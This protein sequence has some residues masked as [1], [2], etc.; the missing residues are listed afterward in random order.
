MEQR[1]I[2]LTYLLVKTRSFSESE[3]QKRFHFLKTPLCHSHSQ[4]KASAVGPKSLNRALCIARP[5]CAGSPSSTS[6]SFQSPFQV[7]HAHT[8]VLTHLHRPFVCCQSP[9]VKALPSASYRIIRE[10]M[11]THA[12]VCCC[13]STIVK[14]LP[15]ASY[16]TKPLCC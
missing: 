8:H 9:I 1:L 13:Q 5:L 7:T 6:M 11:L 15:S 4:S 3:G 14:A 12:D 16:L 10:S 2:L